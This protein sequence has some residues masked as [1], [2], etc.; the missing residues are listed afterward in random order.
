MTK[1]YKKLMEFSNESVIHLTNEL[2]LVKPK[3]VYKHA[4]FYIIRGVGEEIVALSHIDYWD[5][6]EGEHTKFMFLKDKKGRPYIRTSPKGTHCLIYEEWNGNRRY[7]YTSYSK[8]A[9][10]DAVGYTN[11]GGCGIYL[12]VVPIEKVGI[13]DEVLEFRESVLDD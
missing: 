12:A 1:L 5:K 8:S 4:P 2:Q 10:I 6:V 13:T 3:L 9:A 7:T 11:G